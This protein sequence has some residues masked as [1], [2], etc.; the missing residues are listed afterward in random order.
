MHWITL[1][2]DAE[3]AQVLSIL[4]SHAAIRR[5]IRRRL[6]AAR[7]RLSSQH[8]SPPIARLPHRMPPPRRRRIDGVAFIVSRAARA[9]RFTRSLAIDWAAR[10][11]A[12]VL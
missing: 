1:R 7:Q 5:I 3:A 2:R 11:H 12:S 6:S 9:S 4:L 10:G 8:A